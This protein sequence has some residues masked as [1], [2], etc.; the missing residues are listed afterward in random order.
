MIINSFATPLIG[1]ITIENHI[2]FSGAP[3]E[4]QKN[5]P[6]LSKT[7]ILSVAISTRFSYPSGG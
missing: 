5:L 2:T 3:E 1:G 6:Y 7:R 4:S